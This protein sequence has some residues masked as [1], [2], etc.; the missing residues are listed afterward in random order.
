MLSPKIR[1]VQIQ[2]VSWCNR[3]CSFC[4]S[5]KFDVPRSFMSRE[6]FERILDHL[7]AIRFRG[8]LSPYCM[9]EP[10]LDRRLP[11]LVAR[12]RMRL[13]RVRMLLQTNGDAL[14]PELA[15][16][17]V[18]AGINRLIVNVY[19]PERLPVLRAMAREVGRMDRG[20]VHTG[21]LGRGRLS[22]TSRQIQVRDCT[23]YDE[24]NLTNRA[25]NVN[26]TTVSEP[27]RLGCDRPSS[28]LYVRHNGDVVLC[29][30]DW[31][32]EVVFGN[33]LT[34]TLHEVW[35]GPVAK[36]YRERLARKDR[37]MTLCAGC[38]YRGSSLR[39]LRL[40]LKIRQVLG[41][42]A[43]GLGLEGGSEA[44]VPDRRLPVFPER[45]AA[46]TSVRTRRRE[47]TAQVG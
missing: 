24:D 33:L 42:L 13:P 21:Y 18:D 37:N 6:A 15:A 14:K 41:D 19:D 35:N 4:P 44:E 29:S 1:H 28:Q 23:I 8:R 40:R 47:S 39:D 12:A 45:P 36:R 43:A 17:L 5:G 22:P 32:G 2:T 26:G 10:L 27:L 3:S 11:E 46:R 31:K 34:Q 25:G 38:D 30:C 16:R 20:I 9:N 7:A